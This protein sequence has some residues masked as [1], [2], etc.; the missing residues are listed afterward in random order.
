MTC[1]MI[2]GVRIQISIFTPNTMVKILIMRTKYYC[3]EKFNV[4]QDIIRLVEIGKRGYLE[5]A[6]S[7]ISNI[8]APA[9]YPHINT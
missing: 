7:L 4:I 5:L 3:A 2:T 6:G 8:S 9:S 1:L